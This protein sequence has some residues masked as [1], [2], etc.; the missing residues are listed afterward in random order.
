MEWF[1]KKGATLPTLKLNIFKDGRSDYNRS[2]KDLNQDDIFFSMVNTETDI[3][4]ITSRPAGVM[5]KPNIDPTLEPDYYVYYQFTPFDTKVVGRYKAQFLIRNQT[6]VLVL[7]LNDELYIN[8]TDSFIIDD[9]PYVSCY[10]VDFPCCVGSGGVNPGPGPGPFPTTTTTTIIPYTTTSTTSIPYTTTS[11]TLGPEPT[12]YTEWVI[13]FGTPS[14]TNACSESGEYVTAYTP[15][16]SALTIGQTLWATPEFN[17]Y[18]FGTNGSWFKILKRNG[19]SY[20]PNTVIYVGQYSLLFGNYTQVIYSHECGTS[21]PCKCFTYTKT[22]NNVF[23]S[24]Y[25]NCNGNI[26]GITLPFNGS[27]TFCAAFTQPYDY[28]S[29]TGGNNNCVGGICP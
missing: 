2:M 12:A 20:S 14:S 16:M 25:V 4:R 29:V 15:V 21:F 3:P 11:T 13:S 9:L 10:V 26:V 5:E 17:T 19:L 24:L 18:A 27:Q 23:N 1:I 7:P 8:V 22:Q 6:G 28:I